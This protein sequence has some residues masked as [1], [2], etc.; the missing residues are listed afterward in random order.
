[1]EIQKNHLLFDLC[2]EIAPIIQPLQILGFEHMGYQ[3]IYND[4]TTLDIDDMPEVLEFFLVTLQ[5][6]KQVNYPN[7]FNRPD[8]F[9]ESITAKDYGSAVHKVREKYNF[10]KIVNLYKAH[11]SF[12]EVFQFTSMKK[13]NNS[14]LYYLNHLDFL[15]KFTYYFT[16]KAACIIKQAE[17]YKIKVAD[18][19]VINNT[20]NTNDAFLSHDRFMAKRYPLG[21][22]YNNAYLTQREVHCLHWLAKGKSTEE[23]AIILGVS[24]HTVERHLENCKTKL[25]C[26]KQTELLIN[27]IQLGLIEI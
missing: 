23:I 27:S 24:Q 5:G 18:R 22:K 11:A 15:K 21:S 17:N 3:R 26:S 2:R 9:E 16:E 4:G 19:F 1:M 20:K 25:Q 7:L 13:E 10:G 6:H 8:G 12:M 14:D